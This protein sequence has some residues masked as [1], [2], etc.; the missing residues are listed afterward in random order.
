M[1]IPALCRFMSIATP[2]RDSSCYS[3]EPQLSEKDWQRAEKPLCHVMKA[4][5]APLLLDAK[6]RPAPID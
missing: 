4:P 6:A 2:A 1:P 3:T 5:S